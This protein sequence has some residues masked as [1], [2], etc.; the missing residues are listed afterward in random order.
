MEELLRQLVEIQRRL[1]RLEALEQADIVL[2]MHAFTAI[3][4]NNAYYICG[5]PATMGLLLTQWRPTILVAGTNNGSNYWTIAL[6]S[7]TD[8]TV[9][10]H[11][12]FTTAAM[13]ANTRERPATIE[14]FTNNPIANGD[15]QL[16]LEMIATGAPGT[17]YFGN[18]LIGRLA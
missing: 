1:E 7:V 14:S 13:T 6:K 2:P 12:S 17:L 16:Y 8:G 15:T 11:A 18:Y 5:M 3:T 10:T 9:G 4:A